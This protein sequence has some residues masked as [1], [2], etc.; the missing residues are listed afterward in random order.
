M[1]AS[2]LLRNHIILESIPEPVNVYFFFSDRATSGNPYLRTYAGRAREMLEEFTQYA[3]RPVDHWD[4]VLDYQVVADS[5][6]A[7]YSDGVL[8]VDFDLADPPLDVPVKLEP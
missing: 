3:V 1:E 5:A 2:V 8:I 7:K 6:K 4:I